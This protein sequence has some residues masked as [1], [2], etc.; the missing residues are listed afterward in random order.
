[1]L[2]RLKARVLFAVLIAV[3][4]SLFACAEGNNAVSLQIKKIEQ[5][6]FFADTS[7]RTLVINDGIEIIEQKAFAGCTGLE[8]VYCFSKDVRIDPSA[9]DGVENA[10]FYC[11]EGSTMEAFALEKGLE[12]RYP[13]YFEIVC[14][15]RLNGAVGLPITWEAAAYMQGCGD[16]IEFTWSVM[17]EGNAQPLVTQTTEEGRFSYTPQKAGAYTV[18][19]TLS[20][21]E[22]SS[23]KDSEPVEAAAEVCF[24]IYEQD[25]NASTADSLKWKVLEA[26]DGEALLITKQIIRNESFFNPE[27]I[28]YKYTYWAQSCVGSASDTNYWGVIAKDSMKITGI[29]P[30]H[31][32]LEDRTFGTEADLYYVH[33]RYWL[34]EVFYETAFTDDEKSRILTVHNLNE[35][36]PEHGTDSGPDSEDKVFFLSYSEVMRYMPTAASRKVT[37][38]TMAARESGDNIGKYWWLRT[39]G[40]AQ[41]FSMHVQGSTGGVSLYGSD[42]G[43]DNVGYRPCVR[44]RIGG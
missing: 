24:G 25:G 39:A 21:P 37:M 8:K 40:A 1:M 34:N 13:D 35:D 32:P 23:S 10:G 44:I 17:L 5:E 11:Y 15:T 7:I 33:A 42:V 14:D 19:V 26:K 6:A 31:V 9:F 4:A 28:K 12:I 38:T 36:N 43:H 30:E 18:H 22:G 2:M 27:W 16:E 41:W 20:R 3:C 29:T